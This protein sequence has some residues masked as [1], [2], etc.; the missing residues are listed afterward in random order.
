MDIR[1][2]GGPAYPQTMDHC[3]AAVMGIPQGMTL[4]DWFAGQVMA[5]LM[6]DS[7][8]DMPPE[9]YAACAYRNADAMLKERNQ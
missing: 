1:D 2:D 9:E 3:R 7:E 4:R 6:A 8:V 5:G